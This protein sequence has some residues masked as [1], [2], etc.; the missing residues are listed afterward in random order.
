MPSGHGV[1]AMDPKGQYEPTL[2]R[3]EHVEF[4]KPA[5]NPYVPAGHGVGAVE[6]PGQYELICQKDMN[7]KS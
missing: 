7:K 5:I 3:P 6:L 1:A 2:Q 4:F